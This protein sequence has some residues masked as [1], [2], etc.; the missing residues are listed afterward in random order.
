MDNQNMDE[1]K[2]SSITPTP[3]LRRK[4]IPKPEKS[5]NELKQYQNKLCNY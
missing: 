1:Q 5:L 3:K 4:S 2:M